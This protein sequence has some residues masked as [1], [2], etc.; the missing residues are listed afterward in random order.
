MTREQY[1]NLL[2]LISA[3]ESWILASNV[4]VPD[5]LREELAEGVGLLRKEV[6]K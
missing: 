1:L 5:Y 4:V 2:M 6:L 3:L